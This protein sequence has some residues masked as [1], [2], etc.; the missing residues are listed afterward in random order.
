MYPR[1]DGHSTSLPQADVA[2]GAMELTSDSQRL[3]RPHRS[4]S[5]AYLRRTATVHLPAVP[6]FTALALMILWSAHDGGYDADTWYWGALLLLTLLAVSVCAVGIDATRIHRALRLALLAFA[7][8]VAWSYLS[9][10]WASSP[11]D[12]LTGSNRA[13]LYLLVFTLFAITSWTAAGALAILLVYAIGVGVIGAVILVTMAGG[14]HSA[15]LFVDGR[16]LSPTGYINS[17]AALFTSA[18]FV[19]I[20]LAVRKG[21]PALLRGVLVAIACEGIQLALLAESR[22][23]LFLLPFMLAGAI[24][25]APARLR[26]AA[27]AILPAAGALA[28]L[29]RV[30]DVFRATEGA[31][32]S[33][34]AVVKAGEHAARAGL[35]V[36]A[37]ILVVATLLAV[38]DKRV[39]IPPP[40]PVLRRVLG[41]LAATLALAVSLTAGLVATHGHP[42]PFIKR[43]LNGSVTQLDTFRSSHFALAGTGRYDIW[44]VSLDAFLA[45]PIG[46]LGQDNFIDYYY[47]RR[48]SIEEPRWTHSFELRLLAHTGL[49]GFAL[50]GVFLAAGLT[51]AIRDRRRAGPA[52]GALAGVAL[53]PLVVW[54]IHGS[55]DWFWEMPALTG[56]ALGFLG[57]AASLGEREDGLVAGRRSRRRIP[58]AVPV[59]AG[60]LAFLT[61]VFVLAFPYLSV[62]EVSTASDI[63]GGDPGAALRDLAVAA[64]LNPLSSDPGRLAGTIALQTGRFTEAE[65]RFHEAISREPGAWFAWLGAGLAASEL[66]DTATARRD[67]TIAASINS[68]QPAVTQALR[69]VDSRTP[70]APSEAFKLLL[71]VQ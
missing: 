12:A 9:I 64:D 50:F 54:L 55:V 66:G 11:G 40:S 24:A 61:A 34:G 10:A 13:L 71:V 3:S 18:A 51:A 69:R 1:R 60:A 49:V 62:R 32:A 36:C 26:T 28:V 68:R 25:V 39:P 2:T 29:P 8:Y 53:L 56:P 4:F 7:L 58:R 59:A 44:R 5:A 21:L 17:N 19:A 47:Q 37:A 22:G 57:M 16:L 42:L 14:H 6:A 38:L 48:H 31:N 41:A 35:L 30:L 43:Q 27:A 15:S 33:Q 63:R 23:W 20:A 45:H 52:T 46:G 70:L 65:S 67:F